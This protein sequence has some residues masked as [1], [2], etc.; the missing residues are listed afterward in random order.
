[1]TKK[2][3]TRY[4]S[5]IAKAIHETMRGAHKVG[6]I[7]KRTMREFDTLCLTTV[8]ELSPDQIRA[9]RESAKASQAVFAS[10]LNV[11]TDLISKW[12]RGQKRPSG[13][14]LKLLSIVKE[15]GLEVL[16]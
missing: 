13:T 12:E 8:E 3:K 5:K 4:K 6:V 14:A 9:L 10:Y 16:A 2:S 11:S 1:M 15:K 7:D